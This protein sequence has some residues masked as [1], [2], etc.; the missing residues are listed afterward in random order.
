MAKPSL[1]TTRVIQSAKSVFVFV[2][3]KG[4]VRILAKVL[5]DLHDG[6]SLPLHLFLRVAFILDSVT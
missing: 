1:I 3:G 6:A 4:K 5:E 2:K